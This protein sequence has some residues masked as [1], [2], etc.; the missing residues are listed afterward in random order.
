[1]HAQQQQQLMQ[2]QEQQEWARKL[3][4][5]QCKAG[6][7]WGASW[8]KIRMR[9]L[10]LVQVVGLARRQ[11][12]RRRDFRQALGC[13]ARADV[14]S[15]WVGGWRTD[16]GR[17]ANGMAQAGLTSTLRTPRSRAAV[18]VLCRDRRVACEMLRSSW[19]A[20]SPKGWTE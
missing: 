20:G 9:R 17:I 11:C 5:K 2:Q 12:G 6:R 14:C 8:R 7:Q 4:S 1:M 19:R 13:R 15:E 3:A 16:G 10:V 18:V